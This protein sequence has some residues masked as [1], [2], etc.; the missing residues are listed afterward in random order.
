MQQSWAK[1]ADA[2][3]ER[4]L[5]DE[6]SSKWRRYMISDLQVVTVRKC[7]LSANEI[8]IQR[9]GPHKPDVYGLGDRSQTDDCRRLLRA[10]YGDIY[11]EEKF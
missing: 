2:C 10:L 9:K 6:G 7:L 11:T 5:V 3:G 4:V 8:R 1:S